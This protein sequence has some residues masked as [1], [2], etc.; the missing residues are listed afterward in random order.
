M[1]SS[2][3]KINQTGTAALAL[4]GTVPAGQH[5]RLVS[6]TCGFDSAPSTSENFTIDIDAN[7]GAPFDYLAYTLDPS[8]AST[9]S[10]LWQPDAEIILEAGD[11]VVVAF[12]NTD[13]RLFGAQITFKAV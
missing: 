13:A 1:S 11:A 7:A 2:I 8:A 3:F 4:T 6:V 10:I 5:Y 12:A 9:T